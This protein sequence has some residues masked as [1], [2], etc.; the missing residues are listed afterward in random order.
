MRRLLTHVRAPMSGRTKQCADASD[1]SK[2]HERRIRCKQDVSG[3]CQKC[4]SYFFVPVLK[5]P[6]ASRKKKSADSD[7]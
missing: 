5:Q 1:G 4:I 6:R 2:G 7:L 3:K